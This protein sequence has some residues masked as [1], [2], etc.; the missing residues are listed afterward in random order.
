M[1]WPLPPKHKIYEALGAVADNRIQIITNPEIQPELF[2]EK[3]NYDII[4]AHQYSSTRNKYYTITYNPKTDEIMTNDNATWYVGYLGY[5]ALALLLYLDA[6]V[7]DKSILQYFADISFKDINQKYNNDFIK[8][9][10][11]IDQLLGSRGLN[12][13]YFENVCDV[14]YEQLV[15]LK[16]KPLG[17]KIKPPTGY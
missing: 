11:E 7:Y 3:I 6:I 14:I 1:L 15:L 8:A 10:V 13:A 2:E 9:K 5:P 17:P 4:T 12:L 16:L